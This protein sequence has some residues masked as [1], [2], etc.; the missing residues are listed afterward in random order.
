MRRYNSIH[1]LLP[2]VVLLLFSSSVSAFP[3]TFEATYSFIA[4]GMDLGETHYKLERADQGKIKQYRFS[5]HTEPTGLAAML[6]KKIIDEESLWKWQN[7]ELRPLYY[8]YQQRG[9]KQRVRTRDFNWKEQKITLTENGEQRELDGLQPGTV[10]EAL[11]LISLMNDLKRNKESLIYPVAKKGGW[12]HYEFSRGPRESITVPA[13]Q[14]ETRQIVRKSSKER[15]FRLW[16]AP[17][18]DY[19]P[20]QV[21][22]RED[23]GKLFQLKLKKSTLLKSIAQSSVK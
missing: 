8:R 7:G 14:F 13:G 19:L 9:K 10:D 1:S 11:F 18:L 20:V 6:V 23:G 22:Y 17:A 21:E 4:K 2:A 3:E 12:S 16:A 15:S 5:T